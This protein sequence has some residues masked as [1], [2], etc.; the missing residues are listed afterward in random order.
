MVEGKLPAHP[1][2]SSLKQKERRQHG[3]LFEKPNQPQ[4]LR[5]KTLIGCQHF[6]MFWILFQICFRNFFRS[7][8]HQR[9]SDIPHICHIFYTHTFF[10]PE[11]FTLKSARIY[12]KKGL[13]T[14]QRKFATQITL[15]QNSVNYNHREQIDIWQEIRW[16]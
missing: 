12:D 6:E 15:R 9:I 13:A 11:N 2:W 5:V 1:S 14:K 7:F 10:R 4:N 8:W 16:G 3:V